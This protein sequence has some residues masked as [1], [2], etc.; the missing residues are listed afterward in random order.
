[1]P[2]S[3]D[4]RRLAG[5]LAVVI[6]AAAPSGALAAGGSSTTT[7]SGGA[8]FIAGPAPTGNH[9]KVPA[10]PSK[11]AHGTWL[12]GVT[13]TE[14][15]PA[16]ESW[17]RGKPVSAPGLAGRHRIDWLY[18]A[19][20]VSMEGEGYGLDGR[21]YH[22]DSLGDGGWV[23]KSGQ[24]TSAGDGFSAGAPYWRAGGYWRGP[25]G[26]VTYPLSVGG[27]A[28]GVG[29]RYVPL[30]GVSFAPGS[31][32]PIH[33]YQSIAVDP[34]VIPLGSRVYIP[35][36]RHDGHGGWFVAQ[37]TGGAIKGHHIDVYRNPPR[38]PTDG[39]QYLV[40]K[41]AFVIKPRG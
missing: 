12:R 3:R 27:W 18:S 28:N 23:T 38:S 15:W 11:S 7:P 36:Y 21:M 34:H 35:A 17:F 5:V 26:V 13:I 8:S 10:P 33:F 20:G 41:S 39:G 4:G 31:S 40:G 1:V 9:P 22:I 30:P 29:L 32:L 25:G 19:E 6:A 16:P 14:Y 2:A 24:P 37:D